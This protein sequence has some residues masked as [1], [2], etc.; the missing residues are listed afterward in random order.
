MSPYLILLQSDIPCSSFYLQFVL[1]TE[2]CNTAAKVHAA[3]SPSLP[4][5]MSIDRSAVIRVHSHRCRRRFGS[6]SPPAPARVDGYNI[7]CW[8]RE[9]PPLFSSLLQAKPCAIFYS[10]TFLGK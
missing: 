8:P 1:P 5:S 7:R 6:V 2:A 3:A 4:P 9:G 10:E